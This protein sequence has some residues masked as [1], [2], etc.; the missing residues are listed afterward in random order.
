MYDPASSLLKQR[1]PGCYNQREKGTA[2]RICDFSWA[3]N[4]QVLRWPAKTTK[5]KEGAAMI[6]LHSILGSVV[7]LLL[8]VVIFFIFFFL[9]RNYI[10]NHPSPILKRMEEQNQIL[11]MRIN[12]LE[13]QI[14]ALMKE[15]D[16]S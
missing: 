1:F 11:L 4:N 5:Q 10:Y 12:Q 16:R 15:K 6:V 2:V 7:G 9:I 8:W 13:E 3:R 14:D